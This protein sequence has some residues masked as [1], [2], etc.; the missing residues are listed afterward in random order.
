MNWLRLPSQLNFK[1]PSSEWRQ[2]LNFQRRKLTRPP[3]DSSVVTS[4]PSVWFTCSVTWYAWF[5][6]RGVYMSTKRNICSTMFTDWRARFTPPTTLNNA[7]G[8]AP[9][10][11]G[12]QT[13]CDVTWND[14]FYKIR[15]L[16]IIMWCSIMVSSNR[17]VHLQRPVLFYQ[18]FIGILWSL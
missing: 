9:S 17:S 15:Y 4:F 2:S 6:W 3:K 8:D 16:F 12:D 7:A 10:C 13:G 11:N 18:L 5:Q 1:I 14:F